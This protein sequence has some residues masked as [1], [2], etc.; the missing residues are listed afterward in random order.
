MNYRDLKYRLLNLNSDQEF[1]QLALDIFT[2]QYAN[3]K[4]YQEF[5]DYLNVPVKGIGRVEDIPFLP[6]EF[7]KTHSVLSSQSPVQTT[8]TS[9][10][11]TGLQTSKHQVTDID[12]YTNLRILLWQCKRLCDFGVIAFLFGT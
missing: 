2:H 4:V 9:S 3:C 11:T 12:L 7:F 8:F 5:C 6:I 10:G 1:D